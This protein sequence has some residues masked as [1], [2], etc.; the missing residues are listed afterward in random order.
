MTQ[1]HISE[2]LN[3][4]QHCRKNQNNCLAYGLSNC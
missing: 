3:R 2:D 1:H 4:K